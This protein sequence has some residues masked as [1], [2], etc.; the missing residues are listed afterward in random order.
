MPL[1]ASQADGACVVKDR[2]PGD[3]DSRLVYSSETGLSDSDRPS[4]RRRRDKSSQNVRA[5][6]APGIRLEL[7]RRAAGRVVTVVTGLS[8]IVPDVAGLARALKAACGAG[9]TFKQGRMEIQGD[10]RDR[11]ATE[12]ERRGLRFKR[13][14]G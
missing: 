1:R 7:D 10:Q 11:V 13:A 3:R 4:R 5:A 6:K 8:G 12:L 14:G 9:G 2:V